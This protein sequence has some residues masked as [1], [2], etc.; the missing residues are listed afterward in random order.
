MKNKVHFL[1]S[2]L[3]V[4][5]VCY[6]ISFKQSHV[7][8]L[9]YYSKE[10]I[11]YLSSKDSVS[12]DAPF[13]YSCIGEYFCS[14]KEFDSLNIKVSYSYS[15]QDAKNYFPLYKKVRAK[16]Y[17][18]EAS[19]NEKLVII[20]EAHH[21]SRHR[22]FT[23]ALLKDMYK[24]G[25]RYFGVEALV[26]KPKTI[27]SLNSRKYPILTDGY[28]LKE[29]MYADLIREA[30]N[31]GFNVFAYECEQQYTDT[32]D[33]E[34][35]QANNIKKII[36]KDTS[37]RILVHCGWSHVYE[38][39]A[40][41]WGKRMAG[42]LYEC[43]R[44]NPLTIDQTKLIEHSNVKY[45]SP[46]YN[47]INL[48]YDAVLVDSNNKVFSGFGKKRVD[49]QVFHPRTRVVNNRPNWIYEN[50]REPFYLPDL[51]KITFPCLVFAYITDETEWNPIPFDVLELDSANDLKPLSLIKNH[52]YNIEVRNATGYLKKFT[53]DF[54]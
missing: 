16:N 48:D 40:I 44:I 42:R 45:E 46:F 39:S 27:N 1:K 41:G 12:F 47:M 9:K 36:D 15:F 32:K 19:K 8:H 2:T 21:I 31:C 54:K 28:Y 35:C 13:E 23:K 33:R 53:T 30:L 51:D 3:L 14:L 37:A 26:N 10:E 7:N 4:V 22:V 29:P 11:A 43:T 5:L 17:I 20:N 52:R 25:F 49:I 6:V 18:I 34:V 38:D 24:I 50:G